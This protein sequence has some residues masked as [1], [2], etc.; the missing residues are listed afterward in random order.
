MYVRTRQTKE[1]KR[2]PDVYKDINIY[3]YEQKEL[4]IIAY[5]ILWNCVF[6]RQNSDLTFYISLIFIQI[7]MTCFCIN[8]F[9]S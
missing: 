8:S 3:I 4:F 2:S 7:N 5:N 6:C 9:C 1:K